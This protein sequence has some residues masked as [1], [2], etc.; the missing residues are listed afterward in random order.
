M[1]STPEGQALMS[2]PEM[3]PVLRDMQSGGP[4]AAMR[5]MSNPAVMAKVM[6]L[7]G[8]KK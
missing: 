4:M 5:H 6:A 2:D 8:Q 1:M 7:M 3:A